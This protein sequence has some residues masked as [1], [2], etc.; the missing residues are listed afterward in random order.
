MRERTAWA[1]AGE[2]YSTLRLL[3]HHVSVVKPLPTRARAHVL[4]RL[5]HNKVARID[6]HGQRRQR[7]NGAQQPT[8]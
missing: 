7:E 4:P 5:Q 6:E 2:K 1:E 3:V 8:P